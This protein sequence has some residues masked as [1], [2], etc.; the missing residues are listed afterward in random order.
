MQSKATTVKAY[1]DELPKE[2]QGPIRELRRVILA[3]LDAEF[4]EGMLYG[5]IGYSVPHAIFPAGY[6]CDPAK[7]LCVAALASQK[8][9]MSLYLMCVYGSP[10]VRAWFM[11]AWKKSGKKLD[12]GKSCIRFKAVEDLALDVIG[13]AIK[14]VSA[15]AYVEYYLKSLEKGGEA[16]RKH[17]AK[18][19]ASGAAA[20]A[21]AKAGPKKKA[22]KKVGKK[23]A[24]KKGTK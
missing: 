14:K 23:A 4:Q 2:R 10:E 6:H 21:D 8:G 9:H 12:I 17:A 16:G 15:R 19:R 18:A 13:A 5:M 1:I 11:E 3:N 24:K 7:P 20:K 22:A